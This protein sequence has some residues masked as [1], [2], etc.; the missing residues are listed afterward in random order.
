[1][2]ME[3]SLGRFMVIPT[4]CFPPVATYNKSN[5][6]PGLKFLAYLY[7]NFLEKL[8]KQYNSTQIYFA[9]C[10]FSQTGNVFSFP[11]RCM[12]TKDKIECFTFVKK[13]LTIFKKL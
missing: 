8:E 3:F 2:H 7:P 11:Q 6:T 4:A 13:R 5:P 1:M 10:G 12:K 9:F